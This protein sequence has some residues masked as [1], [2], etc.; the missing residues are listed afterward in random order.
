MGP[1][2]LDIGESAPEFCEINTDHIIQAYPNTNTPV[3]Y[4]LL[5]CLDLK[6]IGPSTKIDVRD[7]EVEIIS[8]DP[9]SIY[10]QADQ[11]AGKGT[12]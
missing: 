4:E 12:K 11:N 3:V 10:F 6:D 2:V 5:Q 8:L 7:S 1:A 9:E